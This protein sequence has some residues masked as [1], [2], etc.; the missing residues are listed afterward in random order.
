M[1]IGPPPTEHIPYATRWL[2]MQHMLF[3]DMIYDENFPMEQVIRCMFGRELRLAGVAAYQYRSEHG[4]DPNV[5]A[6]MEWD[7]PIATPTPPPPRVTPRAVARDTE[8][9]YRRAHVSV[10][11]PLYTARPTVRTPPR[12]LSP[13]RRTT[14]HSTI[15]PTAR[16]QYASDTDVRDMPAD[17]ARAY[18]TIYPTTRIE[19]PRDIPTTDISRAYIEHLIDQLHAAADEI[20]NTID[21]DDRDDAGEAEMPDRVEELFAAAALADMVHRPAVSPITSEPAWTS[22]PLPGQGGRV[23]DRANG[24]HALDPSI[25]LAEFLNSRVPV[26][27]TLAQIQEGTTLREEN[28]AG[29][30]CAVCQDSISLG[31]YVRTINSCR[32]SFHR[33]CIDTWLRYNVTCPMCRFDI[34][35]SPGVST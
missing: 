7:T 28:E 22:G 17:I 3:P 34:R 26:V 14:L 13:E 33:S 4:M 32:H 29:H 25:M 27:P 11:N 8:P 1:S 19:H 30:A 21:R 15:Y 9:T 20:D 5:R 16:T 10:Q 35:E 23:S 6:F 24:R 31:A 2:R 12:V 18:S